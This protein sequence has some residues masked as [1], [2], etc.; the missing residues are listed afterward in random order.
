MG[1]RKSIPIE[2]YLIY[3]LENPNVSP[4]KVTM[5]DRKKFKK[6]IQDIFLR[7]HRADRTEYYDSFRKCYY[8]PGE[9]IGFTKDG[10]L[11]TGENRSKII[12]GN[13][14]KSPGLV[15]S[16]L[17][18]I[19]EGD[20]VDLLEINDLQSYLDKYDDLIILESALGRKSSRDKFQSNNLAHQNKYRELFIDLKKVTQ[21]PFYRWDVLFGEARYKRLVRLIHSDDTLNGYDIQL[22]NRLPNLMIKLIDAK[23]KHFNTNIQS[24]D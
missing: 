10:E 13:L 14:V 1:P 23:L 6:R 7:T 16:E 19:R 20:P 17:D 24:T 3:Y 22:I 9:E 15:K 4:F 5:G 12:I 11:V 8:Q 2:N 18:R 21:P